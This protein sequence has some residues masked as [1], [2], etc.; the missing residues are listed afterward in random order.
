MSPSPQV[1]PRL[2]TLVRWVA[3]VLSVLILFFF[4]RKLPRQVDSSKLDSRTWFGLGRNVRG[5]AEP[6]LSWGRSLL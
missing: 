6:R 5:G 4:A 3:H 1:H 2:V